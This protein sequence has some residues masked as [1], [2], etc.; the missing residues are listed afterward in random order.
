MKCYGTASSPMSLY[1][2]RDGA[3]CGKRLAD[4]LRGKALLYRG[5]VAVSLRP[6]NCAH[7]GCRTLSKGRLH[8]DNRDLL[9]MY[10]SL[11]SQ[12]RASIGVKGMRYIK[13]K[14]Q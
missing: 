10:G 6:N 11:V 8:T 1:C 3:Q 5:M 7:C 14:L 4:I 12:T 13:Q 9:V 2:I